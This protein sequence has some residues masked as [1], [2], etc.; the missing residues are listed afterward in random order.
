[1]EDGPRQLQSGQWTV[2]SA[3]NYPANGYLYVSY[4]HRLAKIDPATG[5]VLSQQIALVED[6][7]E[8]MNVF[9]DPKTCEQLNRWEFMF[10]VAPLRF[11]TATGSPVNPLV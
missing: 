9:R 10:M 8:P 1:M 11:Y 3:V 6:G 4:G 5:E 7:G 2:L